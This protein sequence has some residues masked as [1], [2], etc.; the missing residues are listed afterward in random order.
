M[1][2]VGFRS[3]ETGIAVMQQGM[4]K[5]LYLFRERFEGLFHGTGD[6]LASFLLG[7]L[8]N[9]LSLENAVRLALDMTHE[10]IVETLKDGEPLRYGMQFEKVLPLFWKSL[11]PSA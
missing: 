2:D 3:G 11:H 7:A 8:M 10:S 9:G 4:E 5:P 1:T 6:V